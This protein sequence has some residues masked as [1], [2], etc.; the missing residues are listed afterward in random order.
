M[1]LEEDMEDIKQRCQVVYFIFKLYV[2]VW[3]SLW[4]L[5]PLSTIF[6]LYV[7]IRFIDGGNQ[8]KP[9]TCHKSL[10]NLITTCC[11]ENTLPWTVLE[12]TT[13]VA[14]GTDCTGSWESNYHMITT[15]AAPALFEI[16]KREKQFI[17]F[18]VYFTRSVGWII[19]LVTRLASSTVDQGFESR[20]VQIK[21]Y[22]IGICCFPSK[23]V[24]LRSKSKDWL[25]WKQIGAT[26]LP[27]D[28]FFIEQALL[29][30]N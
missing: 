21:D 17:L 18:L 20:A 4:C 25:A 24:A 14:M 5:T 7:A 9:P 19:V 27:M 15:A 28:C 12:L 6:Q 26:C 8:R 3:F 30:S 2:M 29:N 13:V 16:Y 23:H 11:I 22:K 10:T 1:C